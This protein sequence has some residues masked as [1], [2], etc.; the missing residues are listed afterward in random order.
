MPALED[1]TTCISRVVRVGPNGGSMSKR[2]VFAVP[3]ITSLLISMPSKY[4][5]AEGEEV[6]APCATTYEMT[7]L[8][9]VDHSGTDFTCEAEGCSRQVF[10]NV[11]THGEYVNGTVESHHFFGGAWHDGCD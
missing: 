10:P 11:K 5:V 7:F 2:K 1:A 6:E 9:Y 4:R 3:G 8:Y